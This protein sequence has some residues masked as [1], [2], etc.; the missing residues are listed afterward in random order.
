MC[1]HTFHVGTTVVT[2]F[3]V[4]KISTETEVETLS[5]LVRLDV[6]PHSFW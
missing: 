1:K 5:T 3:T 6:M 2:P 4:S